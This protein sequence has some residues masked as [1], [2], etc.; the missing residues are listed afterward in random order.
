MV[1]YF[2]LWP[3][4]YLLN[5]AN[6]DNVILACKDAFSRHGIPQEMISDNGSQ[7]KSYKFRKVATDW[8]FTHKTSSP[9]YPKAN[10]MAE[11]TVKTVKK[12]CRKD[13]RVKPGFSKRVIDITKHAIIKWEVTSRAYLWTF[14]KGQYPNTTEK[15]LA[16][17]HKPAAHKHPYKKTHHPETILWPYRHPKEKW[18]CTW[19]KGSNTAWEN[20]RMEFARNH[21]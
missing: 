7:Y 17:Q 15:V 16:I 13:K 5:K 18:F 3:E 12:A 20:Q 4:V 10:G 8:Q 14:T 21:N 19:S 6:S 9:Y 2:S 1:D 11:A